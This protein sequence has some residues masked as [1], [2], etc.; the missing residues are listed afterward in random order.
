MRLWLLDA[1]VVIKFLEIDVF[2]KLT[3]LHKLH[4]ASSVI[5]EIKYYLRSGKKITVNFRQQY[6]DTG[7]VIE[8]AAVV[9]EIQNLLKRLPSLKQ[10]AIHVGEIESLAIL[11]R[12]ETL[13]LCTFDAAA[14]RIL[15]F[16]D[17]ADRAISAEQLLRVS[18]LTLSPGHKIDPRLLDDYFMSN[19]NKGKLEFVYS[20]GEKSK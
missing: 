2:D 9:D 3:D 6:I 18:G 14:I 7:R 19:L 1:D 10:E 8:F 20:I 17:A 11:V 15:P 4:V 5:D 13:T 12:E 16:L